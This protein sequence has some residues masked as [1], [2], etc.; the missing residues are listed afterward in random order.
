[1]CSSLHP[2]S[3]RMCMWYPLI[4]LWV[5]DNITTKHCMEHTLAW[6]HIAFVCIR[7]PLTTSHSDMESQL[8]CTVQ[9]AVAEVY[10]NLSHEAL[11]SF[12]LDWR[13]SAET[14]TYS[15]RWGRGRDLN[16]SPVAEC[17]WHNTDEIIFASPWGHDK[18]HLLPFRLFLTPSPNQHSHLHESWLTKHTAPSVICVQT[19]AELTTEC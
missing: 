16:D 8:N 9:Q 1:M 13:D 18:K 6:A 17:R 3:H 12:P 5:H 15:L 7:I 14:Q 10:V 11:R 19:A 2:S 4:Y